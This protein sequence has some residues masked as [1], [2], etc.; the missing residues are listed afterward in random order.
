MKVYCK[1]I[2]KIYTSNRF[3]TYT[4]KIHFEFLSCS[5]KIYNV[6]QMINW[7]GTIVSVFFLHTQIFQNKPNVLSWGLCTSKVTILSSLTCSSQGIEQCRT[8]ESMEYT[9]E[10]RCNF[11]VHI[12][13]QYWHYSLGLKCIIESAGSHT[14]AEILMHPIVESV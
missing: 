5:S 8:R 11:K 1:W 4:C 10:S 6:V 7:H 14:Y 2:L 13:K 3:W 9:P 12:I